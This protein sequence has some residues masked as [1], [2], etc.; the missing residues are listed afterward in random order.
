[1]QVDTRRAYSKRAHR[2][3]ISALA[4]LSLNNKHPV[5]TRTRTLLDRITSINQR[6]QARVAA[7]AVLRHR[8]IVANCRRQVYHG[9]MERR[10]MLTTLI[11]QQQRVERLESTDEHDTVELELLELGCDGADVDGGQG[12]VGAQLG[13]TACHPGVDAQPRRLID[14][15]VKQAAEAVVHRESDVSLFEAVANCRAGRGV[16]PTSRSTHAAGPSQ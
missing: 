5:P 8:D 6:V 9:D 14:V 3:N 13:T 12:A 16:H 10:I 11:E 7:Q 4:S 1:M 2:G 15:V